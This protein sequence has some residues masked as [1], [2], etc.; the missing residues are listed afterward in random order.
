MYLTEEVDNVTPA[1]VADAGPPPRDAARAL[2]DAGP[3]SP[4]AGPRS[5]GR[6]PRGSGHVSIDS[7]PFAV[8]W[9]D[10][11]EVGTTPLLRY[12]L[13]DGVHRVIA[14]TEDGRTRRISVRVR[15]GK[16]T[17]TRITFD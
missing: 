4:D 17:A 13:A 8:L 10:G 3:P 1:P 6:R 5:S 2:P 15:A 14:R 16:H 11:K 9:I 7:S 12:P